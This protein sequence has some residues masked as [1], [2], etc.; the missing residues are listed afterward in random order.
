M[1]IHRCRIQEQ[2]ADI[3]KLIFVLTL[4]VGLIIIGCFMRDVAHG[5][6]IGMLIGA[7]SGIGTYWYISQKASVAIENRL[8]PY[9]KTWIEKRGYIVN[10]DN[11]NY[12]PNVHRLLR[13]DSQN[14]RFLRENESTT[15]LFGP[16]YILRMFEKNSGL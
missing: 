15:K 2:L 7:V 8:V 9:A 3:P 12:S 5:A 14:I 11:Q 4:L 1:Q 13:F 10:T 16:Y 6:V